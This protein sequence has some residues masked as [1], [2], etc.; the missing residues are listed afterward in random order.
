MKHEEVLIQRLRKSLEGSRSFDHELGLSG[1]AAGLSGERNP[2]VTM[3]S[4]GSRQI[5]T[6]YHRAQKHERKNRGHLRNKY[7]L[8][9]LLYVS[10]FDHSNS[11]RETLRIQ[12][13]IRRSS[14][15]DL[16]WISGVWSAIPTTVR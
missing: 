9:K 3:T 5:S 4:L 10:Y 11:S 16:Y 8:M 12:N 7:S 6:R 13:P 2:Q 14:L 15:L 1:I